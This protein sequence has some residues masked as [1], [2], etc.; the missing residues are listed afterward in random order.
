MKTH[1][2]QVRAGGFPFRVR[3]CDFLGNVRLFDRG[4]GIADFQLVPGLRKMYEP[5][6][7][8]ER[9]RAVKQREGRLEIAVRESTPQPF[10][11]MR[12]PTQGRHRSPAGKS[13]LAASKFPL[14]ISIAPCITLASAKRGAISRA[15]ARSF[16]ADSR[17]PPAISAWARLMARNAFSGASNWFLDTIARLDELRSVNCPGSI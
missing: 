5:C 4:F 10:P 16:S 17:C 3:A 14:S 8:Q 2:S 7:R 6:S 12:R 1:C 13:V 15:R 9:F 11:R